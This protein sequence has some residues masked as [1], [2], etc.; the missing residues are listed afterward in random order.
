[1]KTIITFE[2]TEEGL[3]DVHTLT[4]AY[5]YKRII[6][7][8]LEECR[9]IIKYDNSDEAA[10]LIDGLEKARDIIFELKKEYLMPD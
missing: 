10:K 9:R 2:I 8:F 5:N 6:E 1:M 3:N 7:E 4:N